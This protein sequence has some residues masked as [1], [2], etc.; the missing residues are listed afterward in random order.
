MPAVPATPGAG[1]PGV[2]KEYELAMD[3]LQP[4][5]GEVLVDMSCGSGLFTRRFLASKRFAGVIAADF[6]WVGSCVGVLGMGGAFGAQCLWRY[7]ALCMRPH[8][9]LAR[10]LPCPA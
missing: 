9:A 3:Y 5:Q 7:G 2:D 10:V 6:R 4:A 1:F 8:P